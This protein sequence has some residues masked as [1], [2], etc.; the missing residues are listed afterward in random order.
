MKGEF[1]L[2][3]IIRNIHMN[4]QKCRSTLQLTLDNDLNVPDVK[5]DIEKIVRKQGEVRINDVKTTNGR[6]ILKGNLVFHI[7]YIGTDSDYQVQHMDGQIPFEEAVNMNDSCTGDNIQVRW[8]LEDLSIGIINS[9]KISIKSILKLTVSAEE[10]MD[11]QAAVGISE[12]ENIEKLNANRTVTELALSKKDIFRIK[13]EIRIPPGRESIRE[14]MYQDVIP[15]DIEMRLV[16]DQLSLRGELRV[17]V[18]YLSVDDDR[19]NAYETNVPFTGEIDC[20][21]CDENMISQ[22]YIN[23]QD[24]DVQ[25]KS[26]E[27]GE[28]RILDI[29]TV[30]GMDIKVYKENEIELL[31]DM[32]S[33]VSDI[34]PVFREA[35]FDNLIMKNNSKMRINDRLSIEDGQPGILQICNATGNVRIDEENIVPGGIQVEGILEIHLLYFADGGVVLLEHLRV[36]FLLSI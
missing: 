35:V 26:D 6:V 31:A 29:E 11:E 23:V 5:P 32:Y 22:V 27:D 9:R 7:L 17:F 34:K 13:D 36:P 21:G 16:K 2:E 4:R 30:L 25:F 8:E 24:G 14:I 12:D 33:T 3:L 1:H 10:I 20:N 28:D 19:I 18:L 15:E